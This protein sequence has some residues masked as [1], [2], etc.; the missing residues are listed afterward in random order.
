V[1]LVL[2]PN[3]ECLVVIVPADLIDGHCLTFLATSFAFLPRDAET[4][5]FSGGVLGSMRSDGRR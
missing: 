5:T 4:T 2:G 3:L 1:R